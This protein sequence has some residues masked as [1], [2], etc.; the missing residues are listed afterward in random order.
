MIKNKFIYDNFNDN[1]LEKHWENFENVWKG[2]KGNGVVKDNVKIEEVDVSNTNEKKLKKCLVLEAHGDLYKEKEPKGL[3]RNKKGSFVHVNTAKRV[4]GAVKSKYMMG[5]GTYDMRVKFANK[6][7]NAL[8]LYRYFEFEEDD[9][10]H[11]KDKRFNIDNEIENNTIINHEIDIEYPGVRED[12]IRCNHYLSTEHKSLFSI[13]EI[14][15]KNLNDDKWHDIRIEW[16]IMMM[17][18]SKIIKRKVLNEEIIITKDSSFLYNIKDKK[19]SKLNG[20]AVRKN[21]EYD[22]EYCMYYG[23]T[24][25]MYIDNMSKPI[26]EKII[27][28][29]EFRHRKWTSKIPYAKSNFFI[30]NWFPEWLSDYDFEVSKLYVDYFKYEPNEDFDYHIYE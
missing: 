26:Y 6:S 8:W 19:Y 2:E 14:K 18:I 15:S 16:N 20:M 22:N 9:Y 1:T 5:P 30:A 10:R 13:N 7:L 25:K 24:L 17:P 3:K 29:E 11:C 27:S 12:L 4:G 23:K 28:D 21:I